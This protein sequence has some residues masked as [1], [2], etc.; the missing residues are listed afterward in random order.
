[1]GLQVVCVCVRTHTHTHTLLRGSAGGTFREN[2]IVWRDAAAQ[3]RK[4]VPRYRPKPPVVWIR[5]NFL[6]FLR[7][8]LV[9]PWDT[10]LWHELR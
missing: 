5:P 9:L 10:P 1:M 8:P 4:R 6:T 7:G 2:T 3:E